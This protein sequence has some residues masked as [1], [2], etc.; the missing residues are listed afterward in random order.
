[1]CR[2]APDLAGAGPSVRCDWP[3]PHVCDLG[4]NVD[5]ADL[6]GSNRR[7]ILLVQ[8]QPH[9]DRLCRASPPR[10]RRHDRCRRHRPAKGSTLSRDHP[11]WVRRL[12]AT[13]A[14]AWGV[15][16]KF[17][18]SGPGDFPAPEPR[19]GLVRAV[20]RFLVGP[21]LRLTQAAREQIWADRPSRIFDAARAVITQ[22]G[23]LR[24]RLGALGTR[25][26]SRTRWPPRTPSPR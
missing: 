14:C 7:E 26:C 22:T 12:F 5:V 4:G 19:G 8:G 2:P 20:W 24:G 6:D 15:N 25:W 13:R 21:P 16:V 9:R 17:E 18:F 1:V 10:S 23:V 11:S 3:R